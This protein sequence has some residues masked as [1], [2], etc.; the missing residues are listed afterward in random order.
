MEGADKD[1]D[2][3]D[4]ASNGNGVD[5]SSCGEAVGK[6]LAFG[7]NSMSSF[8]SGAI[9]FTEVAGRVAVFPKI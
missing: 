5:F 6:F 1:A 2:E 9:S 8:A 4:L 3:D 7:G